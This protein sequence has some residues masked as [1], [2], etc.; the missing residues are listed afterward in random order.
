MLRASCG[1]E[2]LYHSRAA[3]ENGTGPRPLQRDMSNKTGWNRV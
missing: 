3:R 2:L 1:G